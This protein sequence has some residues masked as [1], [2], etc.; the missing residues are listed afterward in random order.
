MLRAARNLRANQGNRNVRM[1]ANVLATAI[2]CSCIGS[3]ALAEVPPESN[4]HGAATG[5]Q[6]GGLYIGSE[7]GGARF[8]QSVSGYD[9]DINSFAWGVFGGY[10]FNRWVAVEAG[11]RRANEGHTNVGV[12]DVSVRSDGFEG[13]VLG[14][15]PLSRFA[16]L[17]GRV[18]LLAWNSTATGSASSCTISAF[19]SSC[20]TFSASADG[21]G[22]DGIYGVGAYLG[23]AG[24]AIRLEVDRT[25]AAGT[26][27]TSFTVG[28]SLSF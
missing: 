18:G 28:A 9:L 3:L 27:V 26:E 11:Y 16:A 10:Q 23:A 14:T 4:A 6:P 13:S 20:G 12:A 24:K 7:L 8:H 15:L 22:T 25:N 2:Y 5:A 1:K 17:F 19:G 21:H